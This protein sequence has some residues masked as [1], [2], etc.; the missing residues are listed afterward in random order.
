MLLNC[1]QTMTR[2]ND[3]FKLSSLL[4]E[5][6][7]FGTVEM[8]ADVF[9]WEGNDIDHL[10]KKRCLG[11]MQ[12]TWRLQDIMPPAHWARKLKYK[13]LA[14]EY[15]G[16]EQGVLSF[17]N[18]Q[19]SPDYI[20]ALTAA[21]LPTLVRSDTFY[22]LEGERYLGPFGALASLGYPVSG[23]TETGGPVLSDLPFLKCRCES[24]FQGLSRS[25]QWA[26]IGNTMNLSQIGGFM[27]WGFGAW[28]K[29]P[30]VQMKR[31]LGSF[32]VIDSESGSGSDGDLEA[33]TEV[34]LM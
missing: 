4:F 26:F 6:V 25:K 29:T 1:K 32:E 16:V 18:L 33:G 27:V 14:A 22:W 11:A 12:G 23:L 2:R 10:R 20:E 7:M 9:F 31:S 15:F 17:A 30:I 5:Q 34:S 28:S 3:C 13:E 8:Q 21:V 19:Q 24:Y